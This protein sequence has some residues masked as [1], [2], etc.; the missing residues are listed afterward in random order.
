MINTSIYNFKLSIKNFYRRDAPGGSSEEDEEEKEKAREKA[1]GKGK[2]PR[3]F[4]ETEDEFKPEESEEEAAEGEI[5]MDQI[6]RKTPNPKCRLYWCLIELIAV[7]RIH[8]ILVW[9]RIR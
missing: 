8:D 1:K 5:W 6:N 7:L 3:R 9:I 4:S 2:G